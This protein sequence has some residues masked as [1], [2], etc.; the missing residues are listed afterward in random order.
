VRLKES[1]K[2]PAD[3]FVRGNALLKI[4]TDGQSVIWNDNSMSENRLQQST[5]GR[6]QGFQELKG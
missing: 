3:A 2:V 4:P 6:G 1:L 5:E